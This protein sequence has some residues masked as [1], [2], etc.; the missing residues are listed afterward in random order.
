MV[1]LNC[2]AADSAATS[3][4]GKYNTVSECPVSQVAFWGYHNTVCT[5]AQQ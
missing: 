2:C 4:V 5:R 1:L 3:S